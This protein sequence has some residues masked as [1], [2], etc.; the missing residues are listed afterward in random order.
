[1]LA[2]RWRHARP[3]CGTIMLKHL[4]LA[5]LLA[6]PVASARGDYLLHADQ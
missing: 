2:L 5:I 6:L 3:Y 1:V 4:D